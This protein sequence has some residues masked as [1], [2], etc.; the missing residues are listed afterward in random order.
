MDDKL[1]ILDRRAGRQITNKES[2]MIARTL[3][4]NIRLS[5]KNASVKVAPTIGHRMTIRF[6]HKYMALSDRITNTQPSL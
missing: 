4:K 1:N 3:N 2:Q 5:E 6:R